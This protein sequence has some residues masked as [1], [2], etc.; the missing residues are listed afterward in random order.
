M[1]VPVT[2]R[3]IAQDPDMTSATIR[4][5]QAP[6]LALATVIKNLSDEITHLKLQLH[7]YQRRYH[8]HDPALSKRQ[9]VATKSKIERL[10][11][12]VEKRSDQVYALYDVLE[13]QKQAAQAAEGN[14]EDA[15]AREMD[16]EE[17]EETLMSIGIDPAELSGRVGRSVPFGLDG[18][19]DDVSEG[20]DELPWEG[21]SEYESEEELPVREAGD[22]R[23]SAAF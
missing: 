1:P 16:A 23:R 4:P 11:A 10:T 18:A 14:G 12:E 13:G 19:A 15:D 2:D 17:V 22:K 3:E 6:P 20:S 21:L 9:R 7:A 8:A 5:S